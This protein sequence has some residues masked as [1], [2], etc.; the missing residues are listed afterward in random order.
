MRTTKQLTLQ[1]L[2]TVDRAKRHVISSASGMMQAGVPYSHGYF[3]HHGHMPPPAGRDIVRLALRLTPEPSITANKYSLYPPLHHRAVQGS[4]SPDESV[5]RWKPFL[6]GTPLLW[7]VCVGNEYSMYVTRLAI[8]MR[9]LP[10]AS[11]ILGQF[12]K[13][14]SASLLYMQLFE[15][16]MWHLKRPCLTHFVFTQR[17][18]HNGVEFSKL[19][20]LV[21]AKG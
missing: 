3:S 2:I 20:T 18:L 21:Q 6:S 5:R 15:S 9:C 4:L 16:A 7:A 1:S 13:S 10:V 8:K 19:Y 14:Y 12:C 17:R 11:F